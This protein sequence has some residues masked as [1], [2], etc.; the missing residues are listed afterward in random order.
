MTV[1]IGSGVTTV[2]WPDEPQLLG[3]LGRASCA[4]ATC[5]GGMIRSEPDGR[6]SSTI[7][8]ARDPHVWAGA[9]LLQPAGRRIAESL[10]PRTADSEADL[11]ALLQA[12]CVSC[13]VTVLPPQTD[14]AT[15]FAAANL[16]EG[17]RLRIVSRT[18]TRVDRKTHDD[19]LEGAGTICGA[20]RYE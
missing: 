4:A 10:D 13:H 14:P 15:P 7:W 1:L 16:W 9:V 2:G 5:H 19:L 18:G 11:M 17:S 20:I 8:A 12:R 3:L 6:A